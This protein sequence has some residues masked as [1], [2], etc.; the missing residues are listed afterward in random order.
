MNLITENFRFT[1]LTPCFSGTAE[2]KDAEESELR[3]PPIRGQIRFWHGATYGADS[4]NR[5]WGNSSGSDGQGSRVAL[6]ILKGPSPSRQPVSLLPHK[7]RGQG[8][9]PALPVDA[10][11]SVQLQRLPSSSNDDWEKALS[12]MRIWLIAGTLGYRSSRAAGS[13]WPVEPWAPRT[14]QDLGR[15]LAPLIG[16][17]VGAWAAA[18]LPNSAGRDWTALRETASDTPRGPAYLF[19][20][21]QPRTPSPVRFKVILL[22]AGLTLF[23]IGPNRKSLTDAEA[24]LRS[25]PDPR[26]WE[27]LG[28][29]TYLSP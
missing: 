10:Q 29:W 6:R 14:P 13:V 25:K 8:S 9:R 3:I 23:V 7:T 22:N 24:A 20:N 2:G 5:V 26:R 12:A 17:P 18:F 27:E 15:L 11:A 16:K 21:A 28:P 1:F 19:G 4:V